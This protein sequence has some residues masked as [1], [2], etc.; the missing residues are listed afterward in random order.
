VVLVGQKG[1]DPVGVVLDAVWLLFGDGRSRRL[2]VWL[3]VDGRRPGPSVTSGVAV[4]SVQR[5]FD[6]ER[7]VVVVVDRQ[8]DHRG[9]PR[10]GGTAGEATEEGGATEAKVR[11]ARRGWRAGH[12]RLVSW[13]FRDDR[14]SFCDPAEPGARTQPGC[15][16]QVLFYLSLSTVPWSVPPAR[17]QASPWSV[18]RQ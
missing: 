1:V 17:P 4:R 6:G 5:Q 10:E 16:G 2:G 12:G 8:V 13:V 3:D 9:R 18:S 14:Q 15:R 11:S 7:A